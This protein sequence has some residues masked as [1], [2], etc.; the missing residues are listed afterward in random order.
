MKCCPPFARSSQA[1]PLHPV[2]REPAPPHSGLCI[3]KDPKAQ[4]YQ[5]VKV[6]NKKWSFS[7]NFFLF[8]IKIRLVVLILTGFGSFLT[9]F[10]FG[11]F[12]DRVWT[13]YRPFL[14]H[15]WTILQPR[16]EIFM[17]QELRFGLDLGQLG[18]F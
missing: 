10:V 17:E 1:S 15:L 12:L 14:D 6:N 3:K 16:W 13:I 2:S 7:N 4:N 9:F 5:N 8:N 18:N 11:P